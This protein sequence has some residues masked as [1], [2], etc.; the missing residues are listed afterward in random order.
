MIIGLGRIMVSI[1]QN[2]EYSVIAAHFYGHFQVI[3]LQFQ[4][5]GIFDTQIMIRVL[6]HNPEMVADH[7]KR[8]LAF[9]DR[10]PDKGHDDVVGPI[11]QKLITGTGWNLGK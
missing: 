2:L 1:F 11:K 3:L 4:E 5:T 8:N 6:E 7:V 9:T 10:T